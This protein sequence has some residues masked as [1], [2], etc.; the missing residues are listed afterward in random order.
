MSLKEKIQSKIRSQYILKK[1]NIPN[2]IV[3]IVL[4]YVPDCN[5]D[6]VD[7]LEEFEKIRQHIPAQLSSV[8]FDVGK[9]YRST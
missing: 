7:W 1:L 4:E 9:D 2:L 8:S 6:F 5:W 3:H